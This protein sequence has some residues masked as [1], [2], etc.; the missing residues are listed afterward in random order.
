MIS[1]RNIEVEEKN[2]M[3]VIRIES[4]IDGKHNISKNNCPTLITEVLITIP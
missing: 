1:A 4:T 2:F 3:Q